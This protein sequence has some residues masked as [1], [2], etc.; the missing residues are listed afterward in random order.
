[1]EEKALKTKEIERRETNED[2]DINIYARKVFK[3]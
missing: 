3:Q 2:W 1:V